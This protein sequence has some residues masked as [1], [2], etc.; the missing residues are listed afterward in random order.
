LHPLYWWLRHRAHFAAEL[1]ADD[2]AASRSSP[3]DYARQLVRLAA[4]AGSARGRLL[5]ALPILSNPSDFYR[6]MTML[7]ARNSDS[8]PAAPRAD[9]SSWGRSR[10]SSRSAPRRSSA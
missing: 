4:G 1:V 8:R 2:W 5:G 6:R 10:G 7:L 9:A 3:G